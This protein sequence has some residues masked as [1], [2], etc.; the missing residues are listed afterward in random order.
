MPIITNKHGLP[1]ALVRAVTNDPYNAGASDISVTALI[2][3]PQVRTLRRKH[4]AA[5]TVDASERMWALT[6]QALHHILERAE[7]NELV[8][9]RLFATVDGWVLSGQFDRLHLGTK[10]LQDY[11]YCKTYKAKGDDAWIRQLNILRWL[12]AQHG[13]EV[14]RLQICAIFRDWSRNKA[15]R[16]PSYPQQ[17]VQ[18]IDV[19]VWPLDETYEYIRE[20][21]AL[22]K[23]ARTGT[24]VTCTDEERWYT[25]T[26]YALVKPGGKRALRVVED[27][28]PT[29][30]GAL[31]QEAKERGYLVDERL[32]EFRRCEDYCEVSAFCPQW[33]AMQQTLARQDKELADAP[34][35]E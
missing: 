25:G 32:G 31:I 8:E 7:T 21:I 28:D 17:E 2:D 22:H 9:Q 4:D 12:L 14:E 5:I 19:P 15:R 3:S 23:A 27:T 29:V 10:T 13:H 26:K 11:K 1:D 33:Q 6:G 30:V 20:R 24:S 16:E 18:M 35:T 34:A